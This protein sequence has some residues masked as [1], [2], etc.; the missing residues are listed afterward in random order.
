MWVRII[1]L[2]GRNILD[3]VFP[4]SVTNAM[5]TT[6][7]QPSMPVGNKNL[8]LLVTIVGI[9]EGVGTHWV[10]R[11]GFS[12]KA[13]RRASS[14]FMLNHD[15]ERKN[16]LHHWKLEKNAEDTH[17]SHDAFQIYIPRIIASVSREHKNLN[18]VWYNLKKM[19]ANIVI[20]TWKFKTLTVKRIAE[21]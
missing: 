8:N 9:E 7:T 17:P 6:S 10:L 4:A 11:S 1:Q 19:L 13:C 15:L 3:H 14:N 5:V 18:S 21:D 16:D 2:H 12:P 20:K